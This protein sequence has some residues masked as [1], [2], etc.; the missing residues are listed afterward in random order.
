LDVEWSHA[1]APGAGKK[2]YITS[3]SAPD[4]LADD[5]AA[6]VDAN[7]CGTISISFT[8]CGAPNS[9]F[10]NIIDPLF[11]QAAAQ[12]QSVFVSAGGQGGSGVD[13]ACDPIGVRGVNEMS[14]DPYATSV[15]GT[16]TLPNYDQK[17]NVLGYA[18]E[19]VWNSGDGATG[20]G[21]SA[22]FPK[23]SYQTGPGV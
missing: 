1:I 18:S 22:V 23:P 12:G 17:G 13:S 3:A 8:Y 15:G 7:D 5:I 19:S 20:G 10:T 2:L 16:Q 4:A 9:E 14:A 6:A 21:V 11:Q